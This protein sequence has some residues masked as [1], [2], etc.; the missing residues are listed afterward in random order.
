MILGDRSLVKIFGLLATNVAGLSQF[1]GRGH[2]QRIK[3]NSQL[4]IPTYQLPITN[5]D[6]NCQLPN[7]F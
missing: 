1:L 7:A 3:H 5:Y 2:I 6:L 4:P